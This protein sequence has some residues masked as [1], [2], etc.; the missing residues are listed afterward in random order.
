MTDDGVRL[1]EPLEQYRAKTL[2]AE[3]YRLHLKV[4]R[5]GAELNDHKDGYLALLRA[6]QR[7]NAPEEEERPVVAVIQDSQDRCAE[8]RSEPRFTLADLHDDACVSEVCD[9][10]DEE[11]EDDLPEEEDALVNVSMESEKAD[12]SKEV[13][14]D[15]LTQL[16][17]D[18]A[19]FELLVKKQLHWETRLDVCR[20]KIRELEALMKEPC[21]VDVRH[22]LMY[23]RREYKRALTQLLSLVE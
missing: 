18:T 8:E 19:S 9:V 1:T 22:E 13:S 10:S 14:I 5:R 15:R 3:V 20:R 17:V 7:E 11:V 4:V 12:S 23:Y 16:Q 21:V 6:Y 2:R